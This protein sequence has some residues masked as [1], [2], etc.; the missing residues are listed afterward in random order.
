MRLG[1]FGGTF[2]PIHNGHVRLAIEAAEALDLDRVVLEVAKQSPLKESCF[3]SEEDRLQMVELAVE[4]EPGLAVGR[5]ELSR[6][7]PS[8]A[9]DTVEHYRKQSLDLWL[10]LGADSL[11]ALD[12]W[13]DPDLL[14]EM[15]RLG[16]AE[17]PGHVLKP[18]SVSVMRRGRV[19]IFEMRQM[20]VSS[21][22][23]RERIADG[24]SIR[25]LVSDSVLRFIEEKRLY[26]RDR[27]KFI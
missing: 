11:M 14:L 7:A 4:G 9:V 25:G 8:Y 13:K 24:R 23:I 12:E 5:F 27:E 1:I 3:A 17:R 2:D 15:C 16:V 18:E 20:D 21:T 22:E 6:P 10:L 26:R 19:D